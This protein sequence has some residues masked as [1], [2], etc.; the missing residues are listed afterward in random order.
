MDDRF[1]RG[2]FGRRYEDEPRSAEERPGDYES[3]RYRGEGY[4]G[5]Y[6]QPSRSRGDYGRRD[7]RG[8][9]DR[10][11]DEVRSWFGDEEA[12]RR[13]RQDEREARLRGWRGPSRVS[14]GRAPDYADYGDDPQWARQWGYVERPYER[15][16]M[17]EER[18]WA[19][20]YGRHEAWRRA[21]RGWEGGQER[22]GPS[23]AGRSWYSGGPAEDAWRGRGPYT[24]HGPKGYQRSDERIREDVCERLTEH[25][26]LDARDIE[27]HVVSREVTLQGSVASRADKRLAEDI[28]DSVS[29]VSEIHNQLRVNQGTAGSDASQAT[30]RH[31][32]A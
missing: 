4:Y 10:A 19:D 25:G 11:G 32:A 26:D 7:E 8:F 24:G 13:R 27:V 30:W 2:G 5:G 9:F 28:A 14:P 22:F 12:E 29:G 1:G 3:R 6:Y 31:R 23:R 18:P 20:D 16:P 21:E 15:T 17:A